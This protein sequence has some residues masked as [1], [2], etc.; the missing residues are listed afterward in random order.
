MLGDFLIA[1]VPCFILDCISS[2]SAF[3]VAEEKQLKAPS[4]LFLSER[5]EIRA[6]SREEKKKEIT[7]RTY[8]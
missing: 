1:V 8:E 7:N 3:D 4:F 2:V 5:K 6:M